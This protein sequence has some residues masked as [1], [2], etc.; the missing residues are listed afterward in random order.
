M[1]VAIT[2]RQDGTVVIVA[3]TRTIS[4]RLGDSLGAAVLELPQ[5]MRQLVAAGVT[6]IAIPG[7]ADRDGRLPA[8]A[9]ALLEPKASEPHE[10]ARQQ[11]MALLEQAGVRII[12]QFSAVSLS[13]LAAALSGS[14][15]TPTD[16]GGAFGD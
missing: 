4:V 13:D 8:A 5:L 12:T 11:A 9:W 10:A 16:G 7:R 1:R 14:D 2:L 6:E 3:A 15:A